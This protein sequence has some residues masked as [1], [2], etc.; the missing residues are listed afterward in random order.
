[1]LG[2]IEGG[3]LVGRPLRA[4]PRRD[5]A[6]LHRRR[7]GR[8]RAS[9]ERFGEPRLARAAAGP[10]DPDA[11]VARIDAAIDA[12]PGRPRGRRPRAARDPVRRQ[13]GRRYARAAMIS[14]TDWRSCSGLCAFGVQPSVAAA[15]PPSRAATAA[16]WTSGGS[17]SPASASRISRDEVRGSGTSGSRRSS[18]RMS[19]SYSASARSASWP[20]LDGRDDLHVALLLEH[21]AQEE[22]H[23][24]RV[25]A[26]RNPDRRRSWRPEATSGRW[27]AG[28]SSATAAGVCVDAGLG[29]ELLHDGGRQQRAD[30]V[31]RVG[32]H[33]PV[34][35]EDL[36]AD[37]RRDVCVAK[38]PLG[39]SSSV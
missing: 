32:E 27:R 33:G 1:M 4:R 16:G 38:T 11:L 10:G 29:V 22:L 30:R 31:E 35:V 39:S 18:S 21:G 7:D 6:V 19:A 25:V 8:A 17:P 28:T 14:R 20:P 36:A 2:A 3:T 13:R 24:P 37:Q 15:R 23:G 12:L 9:G 26:D 5:A 34:R